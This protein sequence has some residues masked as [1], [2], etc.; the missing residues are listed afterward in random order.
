MA[1]NPYG[2]GLFLNILLK[3]GDLSGCHP[4][5]FGHDFLEKTRRHG[6]PRRGR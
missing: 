1:W 4:A 6:L 5:E 3:L 2:L